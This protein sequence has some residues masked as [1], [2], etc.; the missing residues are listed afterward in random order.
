MEQVQ[1]WA[2]IASAADAQPAVVV[3][4][5]KDEGEPIV[6]LR[7]QLVRFGGDDCEGLE[8]RSIR[9]LPSVPDAGE[10]ERSGYGYR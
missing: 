5:V 10:G 6:D 8:V 1:G 9:P 7:D 2:R 3:T 4:R